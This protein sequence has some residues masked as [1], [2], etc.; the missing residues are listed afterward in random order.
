M[1]LTAKARKAIPK[2]EFAGP[3]RSFPIEDKVHARKAIQLA[4]RSLHAGNITLGQEE[5]I[6]SKAHSKLGKQHEKAMNEFGNRHSGPHEHLSPKASH[7]HK[8]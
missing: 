5:H 7:F 6:V 1:K 8:L 4:P 2:K 3:G